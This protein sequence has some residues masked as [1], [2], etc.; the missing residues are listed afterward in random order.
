MY[1]CLMKTLT[2][3]L[4]DSDVRQSDFAELV[5]TTQAHISRLCS[6]GASPSVS[7]A[8]RIESETDGQVPAW[9]WPA[10]ETFGPAVSAQSK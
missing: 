8:K 7:L 1:I 5:K 2:Q 6:H 3:Y 4:K 10:F 9:S